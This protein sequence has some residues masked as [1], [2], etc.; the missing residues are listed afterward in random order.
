MGNTTDIADHNDLE[1]P[2]DFKSTLPP[3]KRAKTKEEK[4]QRRIERILRNRKAAHHSRE[5]KRLHLQRLEHKCDVM[6]RLLT[7]IG[8]LKEIIGDDPEG[9]ELINEYQ[10]MESD[11][12]SFSL[13]QDGGVTPPTKEETTPSVSV[14]SCDSSEKGLSPVNM[15]ALTPVSFTKEEEDKS[16]DL[17]FTKSQDVDQGES[18]DALDYSS[19][20]PPVWLTGNEDSSFEFDDWRNPAVITATTCIA[21]VC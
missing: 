7:R 12:E 20:A 4:E 17:L 9:Q 6:Q 19:L 1:I 18:N 10:M 13:A 14:S 2:A 11:S 21:V 3:R 16:W 8:N 5:K 15:V